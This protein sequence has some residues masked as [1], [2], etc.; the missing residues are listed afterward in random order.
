MKNLIMDSN[1]L[2]SS[3]TE[4]GPPKITIVTPSYNQGAFLE[5][6][7]QSVLGQ[8]YLNLEYIIIDGGSADNSVD[9]IRKYES[10]L[11]YWVS[12]SDNGQSEAINKGLKRA[13][14]DIIAWLNS[15][16]WYEPGVLK[17]VSEEIDLGQDR[18]VVMGDVRMLYPDGSERLFIQPDIKF[19]RLLHHNKLY[20]LGGKTGHPSQPSIFWHRSVM[21][22]VGFLD[23]DLHKAMDTD[24][25]LRMLQAGFSFNRI[26]EV[27]SNYPIHEASK[28]GQGWEAFFDEW[29]RVEQKAKAA[30]CP[31]R[32]FETQLWWRREKTSVLLARRHRDAQRVCRQ[33]HSLPPLQRFKRMMRAFSIAPW[34]INNLSALKPGPPSV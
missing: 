24:Y 7:I 21:E 18:Y 3:T 2:S 16:D 11:A 22:A 28:S 5:R 23:E 14:G 20:Q 26:P 12:E 15:D 32:R 4:S 31:K 30:L 25:W 29:S 19:N 8:N 33:A 10:H 27:W 17:R 34:R 13:T 1:R 9:I 6:T